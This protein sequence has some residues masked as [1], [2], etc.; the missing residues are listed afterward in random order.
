M[1]NNVEPKKKSW[2]FTPLVPYVPKPKG[3]PWYA[4]NW[5]LTVMPVVPIIL[6]VFNLVMGDLNPAPELSQ[7]QTL[8]GKV[9]KIQEDAPHVLLETQKGESRWVEFPAFSTYLGGGRYHIRHRT[10]KSRLIG[11]NVEARGVPMRWAFPPNRFRIFELECPAYQITVGGLDEGKDRLKRQRLAMLWP[12]VVMVAFF[13][14]PFFYSLYRE[15]K[16]YG[17]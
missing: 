3:T 13:L 17:K 9:L 11:C 2:W 15:R 5:P 4:V 7:L 12:T 16:Y 14:V 10:K 8:T 1:E 6:F